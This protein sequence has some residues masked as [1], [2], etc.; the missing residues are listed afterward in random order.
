[1]IRKREREAER[2][3]RSFFDAVGDLQ[4]DMY[5]SISNHINQEMNT[6]KSGTIKMTT[7]NIA[8]AGALA[9]VIDR[10]MQRKR[11]RLTSIIVSRMRRLFNFSKRQHRDA[12]SRAVK[13][14]LK[15]SFMRM[16]YDIENDRIIKGGKLEALFSMDSVKQKTI[17]LV[18]QAISGD[19]GKRQFLRQFK[20]QFIGADGTG[21]LEKYFTRNAF[22]I[23]QRNDRI[24]Q[25]EF[26]KELSLSF[27][28]YSGPKDE[29]NRPF[30][31]NRVGKVFHESE[32]EKFNPLAKGT[33]YDP[34][35]DWG[36]V[37]CRHTGTWITDK[38]AKRR[39][40]DIKKFK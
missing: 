37:N 12:K 1:M 8:K 18:N 40:K 9:F 33:V 27:V 15:R 3:R 35:E 31:A 4:V 22:N 2:A 17:L 28:I 21:E 16:G 14:A 20:A 39:G 32:V 7:S 10:I 36:G 29:K 6:D 25:N 26:R 30:C 5:N 13:R 34:F 11:P 19:I 23:F 38:E 24:I